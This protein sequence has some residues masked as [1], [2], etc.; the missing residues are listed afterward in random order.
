M[1]FKDAD[2]CWRWFKK[3]TNQTPTQRREEISQGPGFDTCIRAVIGALR[4]EEAEELV[5]VCT[6]S[7]KEPVK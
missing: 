7:A 1:G 6:E 5:V 4:P 3:L 2:R